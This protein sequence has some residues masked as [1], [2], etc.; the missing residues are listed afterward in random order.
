MSCLLLE[1]NFRSQIFLVATVQ[2]WSN[3]GCQVKYIYLKLHNR[4]EFTHVFFLRLWVCSGMKWKWETVFLGWTTQGEARVKQQQ[5]L[6]SFFFRDLSKWH[7]HT[8]G[9]HDLN[10]SI[11]SLR[12]I[13]LF[14]KEPNQ[15]CCPC[16]A[17]HTSYQCK[18]PNTWCLWT[19]PPKSLATLS[20]NRKITLGTLGFRG[21]HCPQ[22]LPPTSKKNSSGPGW[23]PNVHTSEPMHWSTYGVTPRVGS[24]GYV[25]SLPRI[26]IV[27]WEFLTKNS[28]ETNRNHIFHDFFQLFP[29]GWW[30]CKD[31][32]EVLIGN[33]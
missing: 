5:W 7:D 26:C 9:K 24:T 19:K 12:L 16:D 29:V 31:Q 13:Y 28:Q 27:S 17:F 10:P 21:P 1:W 20:K 2:H 15:K 23:V 22:D 25:S 8:T 30:Q 33:L 3:H 18:L 14:G 6:Q 4:Y 32:Q 11:H